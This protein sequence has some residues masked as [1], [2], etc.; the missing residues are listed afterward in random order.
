MKRDLLMCSDAKVFPAREVRFV[1]VT[2][3]GKKEVR[4]V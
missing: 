1:A 4:G 3:E 2:K